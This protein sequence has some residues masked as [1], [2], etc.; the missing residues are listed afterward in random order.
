MNAKHMIKQH[1][2]LFALLAVLST[3]LLSGCLKTEIEEPKAHTRAI[4]YFEIFFNDRDLEAAAKLATDEH[5]DL[6][7]SY[8]SVASVGRY[9]YKMR[10]DEVEV[11]ADWQGVTMFNQQPN[12]AR[13]QMSFGGTVDGERVETVR[14]VVMVRQNNN[15][16]L[17]RLLD[18][19]MR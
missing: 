13:V 11:N 15:W 14:E 4:E 10:F 9:L 16:Y 17:A 18:G 8:G 3:L 12:T 5:A 19:R 1:R 2:A 6:I 7:L